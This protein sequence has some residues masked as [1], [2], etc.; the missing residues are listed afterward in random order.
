MRWNN[1]NVQIKAYAIFP[2]SELELPRKTNLMFRQ[3]QD[4]GPIFE[5]LSDTSYIHFFCVPVL[6]VGRLYPL[7]R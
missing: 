5:D 7:E 4:Q 2:V 3:R 1:N 6:S